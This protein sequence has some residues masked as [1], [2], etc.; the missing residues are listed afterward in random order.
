PLFVKKAEAVSEAK[1]FAGVVRGSE[2]SFVL[3]ERMEGAQAKFLQAQAKVAE[4]GLAGRTT[5]GATRS[6]EAA[7]RQLGRAKEAL[8]KAEAVA[9]KYIVAPEK[10]R[11]KI[12]TNAIDNAVSNPG[13]WDEVILSMPDIETQRVLTTLESIPRSSMGP[14]KT[15]TEAMRSSI[16]LGW[17]IRA[18]GKVRSAA[19]WI[20]GHAVYVDDA[21]ITGRIL[22][23]GAGRERFV[24]E[25]MP[26]RFKTWRTTV[27]RLWKTSG[28]EGNEAALYTGPPLKKGFV[29]GIDS[30]S[31]RPDLYA[32]MTP[33]QKQVLRLISQSTNE[34]LVFTERLLGVDT[35]AF[36]AT[37]GLQAEGAEAIRESGV[38]IINDAAKAGK[39]WPQYLDSESFVKA[40]GLKLKG[41]PRTRVGVKQAFTKSKKYKDKFEA[42]EALGGR[43]G[44]RF[45]DPWA[46]MSRRWAASGHAIGDAQYRQALIEGVPNQ[47]KQSLRFNTS[48]RGVPGR[49]FEDDVAQALMTQ[50]KVL[51]RD[52]PA[53][54]IAKTANVLRALKLSF[55][56]SG[57]AAIQGF[58][59]LGNALTQPWTIARHAIPTVKMIWG[60][61]FDRWMIVNKAKILR[62]EARGLNLATN[63]VDIERFGS[64]TFQQ[65]SLAGKAVRL[66]IEIPKQVTNMLNDANFG[67]LVTYYKVTTAEHYLDIMR[68]SKFDSGF[69]GLAEKI[70]GIRKVLGTLK[71]VDKMSLDEIEEVVM[72]AVNNRFG[73]LS[74][75][76]LGKSPGRTIVE[77]LFDIAPNWFRAR[78][79]VYANAFGPGANRAQRYLAI[80]MIG[81]ELATAS[82]L[83]FGLS[84]LFTG[85]LPNYKDPTKFDWLAVKTPWGSVPTIPSVSIMRL[86]AREI[87]NLG[88]LGINV[89]EGDTKGMLKA[90]TKLWNDFKNA[91][92]GRESPAIALVVTQLEGTD[93]FGR[94]V[95]TLDEIAKDFSLTT[96]KEAGFELG[97]EIG[98]IFVEDTAEAIERGAS[99]KELGVSAAVAFGGGS[100]V[101]IPAR[102]K[103][104]E[105][106]NDALMAGP[107]KYGPD[108][109][110]DDIKGTPTFTN[111]KRDNPEVDEAWNKVEEENR[112][113]DSNFQKVK[114]EQA[115]QRTERDEKLLEVGQTIQW[116]RVGGGEIYK[117]S[118]RTIKSNTAHT[119][120]AIP[121]VLGVEY[122]DDIKE[123]ESLRTRLTREYY[124]I[125]LDNFQTP[126]GLSFDFDAF[127]D[128]QK[129][130]LGQ[131]PAD[132]ASAIKKGTVF[133]NPQVRSNEKRLTEAKED[134]QPWFDAPKY[135][136]LTTEESDSVDELL[137]L[138]T[139]VSGLL[140]LSNVRMSRQKILGFM[141][142][143]GLGNSK[144]T[145]VAFVLT[146]KQ[147]APTMKN[148]FRNKWVFS[149]PD[150]PVFYPFVFDGLSD[151]E[152]IEWL[153][154]YGI[155][156]GIASALPLTEI[157]FD[158]A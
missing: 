95:V 88:N 111:L 64:A 15:V 21:D 44:V 76:L 126:D 31:Q 7:E 14:L 40:T 9:N 4:Q 151:D 32:R 16:D 128:A 69:R 41:I 113:Q 52:L 140:L 133:K 102:E 120:E 12:A 24:N 58:F 130:K 138:A 49:F 100:L 17:A 66:P 78:A 98:P 62:M 61:A 22:A 10:A 155:R 144:V 71:G 104:I 83:S 8:K 48:V 43:K 147:F 146:S 46:S 121:G 101:P 137:D 125:R 124:D 135:K 50:I 65:A 136:G 23:A 11:F 55:D 107:E 145:S 38:S 112:Q 84:Y 81:R 106:T 94:N 90:R 54:G 26:L 89:Y 122:P 60:P 59:Y 105:I 51:E 156:G 143:A 57:G 74:T 86:V 3:Y 154:R 93:Y 91:I 75:A 6:L 63:P 19:R 1:R 157:E 131:M 119:V 99:G 109:T 114:D 25:M 70:P 116:G 97:T 45:M 127:F 108:T 56:M 92:K 141:L 77:Q 153:E 142:K 85:E 2:R 132:L 53:R 103:A 18:P 82:V 13:R 36:K 34:N 67:R 80:N 28:L 150:L 73:G 79:S 47:T 123:D 27:R 158:E 87:K 139:E 148:D 29:H 33:A 42:W 152:Q 117:D 134:L 149:H 129:K 110:Y 115:K 35:K 39:Y 96:L 68:Y 72:A 118:S 5:V 37:Q 20:L 30:M